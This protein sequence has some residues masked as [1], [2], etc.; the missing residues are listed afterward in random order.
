MQQDPMKT[1]KF[2]PVDSGITRIE[3]TRINLPRY[4]A[5]CFPVFV[6]FLHEQSIVDFFLFLVPFRVSGA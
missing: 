2:D 6:T 1:N 3:K 4:V 5:P